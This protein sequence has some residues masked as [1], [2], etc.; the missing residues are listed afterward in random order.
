MVRH[1]EHRP[2]FELD[3]ILKRRHVGH[4]VMEAIDTRHDC[5]DDDMGHERR[6]DHRQQHAELCG[7]PDFWIGELQFLP[8]DGQ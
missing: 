8:A 1:W 5:K 6:H 2:G 3:P 4:D 7:V